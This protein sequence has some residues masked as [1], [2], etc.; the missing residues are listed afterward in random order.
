MQIDQQPAEAAPIA[1][2]LSSLNVDE[3]TA[4]LLVAQVQQRYEERAA[5][6][7]QPTTHRACVTT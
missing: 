7:Q 6:T 4:A 2:L 5:G 3:E 1:S